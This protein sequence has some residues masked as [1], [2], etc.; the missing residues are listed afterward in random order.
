MNDHAEFFMTMQS[1]KTP[2]AG[3]L[4]PAPGRGV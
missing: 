4:S 2:V 3:C 1:T